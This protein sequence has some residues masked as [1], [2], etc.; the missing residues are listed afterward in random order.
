[1]LIGY[2]VFNILKE[3][4]NQVNIIFID[5]QGTIHPIQGDLEI[6]VITWKITL[7]LLNIYFILSTV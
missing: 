1:M 6:I 2:Q 3:K 7:S 5:Q 4:Q